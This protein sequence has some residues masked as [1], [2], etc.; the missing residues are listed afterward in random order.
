MDLHHVMISYSKTVCYSRLVMG[1]TS[2]IQ[3]VSYLKVASNNSNMYDTQ[4]SL[5]NRY[6]IK[7]DQKIR[8]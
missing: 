6:T 4:D 5:S 2:I 7:V 3:I 1:I 8:V